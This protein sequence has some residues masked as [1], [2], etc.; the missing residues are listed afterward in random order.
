MNKIIY[1]L[2]ILFYSC[3]TVEPDDPV[4]TG[5]N[6]ISF[7]ETNS[8]VGMNM[9]EDLELTISITNFDKAVSVLS[10]ELIFDD[11]ELEINNVT[12]ASFGEIDFQSLEVTDSTRASFSFLGNIQ[13]DGDL[14]KLSLQGSSY[15]GTL[16]KIENL[17]MIS[18]NGDEIEYVPYEDFW[19]QNLCYIDE[20]IL[21]YAATL[22]EGPISQ[23]WEPT[24]NF[25]WST[26]FCHLR[27]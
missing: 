6:S 11:D 22:P 27:E 2:L 9:T 1:I 14:M 5:L 19:I 17:E 3:G 20:G 13:G 18:S 23:G 10:F 24:N 25:V 26:A 16:I 8:C 7:C 4:L 15:E 21:I 12:S